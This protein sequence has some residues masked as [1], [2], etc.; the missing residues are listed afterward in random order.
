M[1][2]AQNA[3]AGQANI[4]SKETNLKGKTAYALRGDIPLIL[5]RRGRG[6]IHDRTDIRVAP[7]KGYVAVF[8]KFQTLHFRG[9][10]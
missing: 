2:V 9:L 3:Q 10:G 7:I 1:T 4:T 5:L 6:F 8:F